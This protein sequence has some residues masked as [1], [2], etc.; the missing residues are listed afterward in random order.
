M[1]KRDGSFVRGVRIVAYWHVLV[2]VVYLIMYSIYVWGWI[3]KNADE[4]F[5]GIGV[6]SRISHSM[7]LSLM[8]MFVIAPVTVK[9][10]K[11]VIPKRMGSC[12]SC[13]WIGAVGSVF[14]FFVVYGVLDYFSILA[15][16]TTYLRNQSGSSGFVDYFYYYYQPWENLVKWELAAGVLFLVFWI[17]Y[18]IPKRAGG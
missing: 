17:F 8:W 18:R 15:R 3:Y 12:N 1:V 2:A 10:T 7:V 9:I 13:R 5:R 16:F 14:V 11:W 6:S 4:G